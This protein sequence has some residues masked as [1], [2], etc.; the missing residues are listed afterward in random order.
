MTMIIYI[1][2]AIILANLAVNKEMKLLI[3]AM[4]VKK[5]LYLLMNPQFLHKIVIKNAI[6]IFI[7]MKVINIHALNQIYVLNHIIY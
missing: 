2:N 1:K 7:L 6:I 5:V 3:I 4:N